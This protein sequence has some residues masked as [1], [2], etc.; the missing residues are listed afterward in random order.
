TEIEINAP[1]TLAAL[2]VLVVTAGDAT[3]AI[4][5]DRVTRAK[6]I[7][8][9]ELTRA[10]RGESILD[11][12][13]LI[14]FA[15]LTRLLGN[16]TT[17][18]STAPRAW[19]TLVLESGDQRCAVGVDSLVGTEN[20]VMRP[21]PP[22]TPK[23]PRVAG[24][25]LDL[26]GNPRLVLDPAGLVTEASRA[27]APVQAPATVRPPILVIDD[28][29]TT[30]MLEQSILESAGYDVHV[31]TSAEEGL[32]KA[33]GH[34]YGLFLVD[35]EMPGM[36]GFSFVKLSRADPSLRDVPAI[37]VTSRNSPED[38]LRGEAVGARA[39]IVKGEFDQKELLERVRTI[40]G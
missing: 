12:G 22:L 7:L 8:S 15:P 23:D 20:V 17:P 34:R 32:E 31:A 4:P 24:A 16:E 28:S 2:E 25:S 19:S 5:L 27:E 13:S 11:E 36:D 39:Y 30:R 3:V 14:P 21:L 26:D 6:R 1:L 37:L 10:Q 29:L 38:R 18:L 9:S 40:V 35:V 33:H